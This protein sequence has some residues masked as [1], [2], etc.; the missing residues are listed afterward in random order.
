MS[1]SLRLEPELEAELRLRLER[2]GGSMSE[3][4]RQAIREKLD[5]D[6]R[7]AYQIGEPL[8]GRYSSGDGDRSVR[9]KEG[10]KARIDAKHRR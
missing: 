8:F 10:V 6:G 9:R 2:D 3:F 7:S 4:V 1:V 5:R